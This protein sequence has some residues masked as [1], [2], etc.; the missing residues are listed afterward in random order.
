MLERGRTQRLFFALWPDK[1]IRKELVLLQRS[2]S[3]YHGK[4]VAAQNLHITLAFI[5]TVDS[6][7]KECVQAR[8]RRISLEPFSMT[9]TKLGYFRRSKV[10]WLGP[11]D[12]P[13]PLKSLVQRL[14]SELE[15]CGYRSDKRFFSPHITLFRKAGPLKHA[16]VIAPLCWHIDRFCLV[17]STTLP[18]GAVYRVLCYYPPRPA[19]GAH[20]YV[21]V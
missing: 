8:A 1:V 3:H 15:V 4:P 5:G 16:T 6:V 18:Q 13:S 10:M 14:N 11:P 9:M 7:M 12:C 20:P 19:D 2:I 17:Q 21:S